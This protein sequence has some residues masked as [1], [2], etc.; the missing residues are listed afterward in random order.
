VL[1]KSKA[2]LLA[3]PSDQFQTAEKSNQLFTHLGCGFVLNPVTHII[4]FD[5]TH[6]TRNAH[7]YLV[8]GK[9]VQLLEPVRLACHIKGGLRDSRAFPR[10]GQIEI[11]FGSAVVVEPTVKS[12]A[13]KLGNVVRDVIWFSPGRQASRRG[14]MQAAIGIHRA[15]ARLGGG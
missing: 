12:G 3:S 15:P 6:E 14:P 7:T 13:L 2:V 4:Q 9:R 5:A 1:Q 11:R 10:R 8:H